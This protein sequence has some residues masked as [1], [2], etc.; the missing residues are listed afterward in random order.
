LNRTKNVSVGGLCAILYEP[1]E[2]GTGVYMSLSVG[3]DRIVTVT[4]TV[5]WQAPYKEEDGRTRYDTG[6]R[7]DPLAKE[8]RKALTALISRYGKS[9]HV[10]A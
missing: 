1:L 3:D 2:R 10:S 8:D 4:G 6:I 9:A 7:F 5:A